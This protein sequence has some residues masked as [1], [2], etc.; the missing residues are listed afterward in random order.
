MKEPFTIILFAGLAGLL[1]WA[2]TRPNLIAAINHL[3]NGSAPKEREWSLPGIGGPTGSGG[4][5]DWSW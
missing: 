1:I 2:A 5:S 3:R 4:G